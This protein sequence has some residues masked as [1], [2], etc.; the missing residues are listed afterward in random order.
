MVSIAGAILWGVLR[1][2]DYF[3]RHLDAV[4]IAGA[5]LWGVLPYQ[6]RQHGCPLHRFNRRGD[7]LGGAAHSPKLA[8]RRPSLF[9]SQGRFFGGCCRGNAEKRGI[10]A[11]FQSQGRF[12]G[13]CCCPLKALP[14][15]MM[16]FQSQGRFFGG[17]C[18]EALTDEVSGFLFQSQGRFFGGCCA[19]AGRRDGKSDVV[20]IAGAILWGVLL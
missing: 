15:A 9:Q 3:K 11:E 20:S 12:F 10:N 7:S 2:A 17:C 8:G 4:S 14:S 18:A 1:L 6:D 13:G 19:Y 16:S 5:I